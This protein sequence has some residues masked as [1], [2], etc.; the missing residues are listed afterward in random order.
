[1]NDKLRLPAREVVHA[2]LLARSHEIQGAPIPARYVAPAAEPAQ[3]HPGLTAGQVAVLS[4][5]LPVKRAEIGWPC[6]ECGGSVVPTAKPGRTV[7]Y[8][9]KSDYA[10]PADMMMPTCSKC[11]TVWESDEL[12]ERLD[13]VCAAIDAKNGDPT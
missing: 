9:G 11:G 12:T 1:M 13:K 3:A 2:A 4:N 10:V 6:A 5:M 7:A 8:R